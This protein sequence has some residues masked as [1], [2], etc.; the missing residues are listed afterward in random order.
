[1]YTHVRNLEQISLRSAMQNGHHY[2]VTTASEMGFFSW[3][4][5]WSA[6]GQMRAPSAKIVLIRPYLP[7]NET[8]NATQLTIW[9]DSLSSSTA[10]W[11]FL[12]G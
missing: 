5:C 7:R 10:I 12:Q 6:D 9:D 3:V 8:K 11:K 1:M 2:I 4:R